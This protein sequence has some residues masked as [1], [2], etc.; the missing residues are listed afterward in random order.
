MKRIYIVLAYGS[1]DIFLQQSY[2][3]KL[4]SLLFKFCFVKKVVRDR[5]RSKR[6]TKKPFSV[7]IR[8][9][10]VSC[11][12][13]LHTIQMLCKSK[14]ARVSFCYVKHFLTVPLRRQK[15]HKYLSRPKE[16]NKF[17][18][19]ISLQ[20]IALVQVIQFLMTFWRR[21]HFTHCFRKQFSL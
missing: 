8:V 11:K 12:K 21:M 16:R 7:L 6:K 10:K 3:L 15:K 9:P 19:E 17:V 2:Q 13:Y 5:R 20:A 14:R 18:N 1:S 4:T